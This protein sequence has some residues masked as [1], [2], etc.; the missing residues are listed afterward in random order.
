VT[1]LDLLLFLRA[2]IIDIGPIKTA[3]RECLPVKGNGQLWQDQ[4]HKTDNTRFCSS[5]LYEIL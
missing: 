5:N 4:D 1:A 3:T 2:I